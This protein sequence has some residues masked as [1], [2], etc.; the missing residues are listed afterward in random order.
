MNENLTYFLI[1]F[2]I[3]IVLSGMFYVGAAYSCR[4]SNGELLN[5]LNLFKIKC[6]NIDVIGVCEYEENY[7]IPKNITPDLTFNSLGG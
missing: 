2:S 4:N 3:I 5:N 1:G 7:Y 6:N